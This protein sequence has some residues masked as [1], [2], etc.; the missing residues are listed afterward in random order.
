MSGPAKSKIEIKN[1]KVYLHKKD[2][3]T[4]SR[5]MHIDIESEELN[6][7]IKDKEATYCAGKPDGVF[8]GLKKKMLERAEKFAGKKE[9]S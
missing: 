8:I 3:S 9:K 6:E 5:I 2:P 1:V 4:N 7:I